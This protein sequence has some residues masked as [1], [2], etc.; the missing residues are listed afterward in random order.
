MKINEKLYKKY[1][2]N[3][4]ILPPAPELEQELDVPSEPDEME[5]KWLKLRQDSEGMDPLTEKVNMTEEELLD[6]LTPSTIPPYEKELMEALNGT[7]KTSPTAS[8]VAPKRA[9]VTTDGVVKLCS[10]YYDLCRKL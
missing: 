7:G 2:T 8:T 6:N 5:D 1:G 10:K 3:V 4:M 9:R